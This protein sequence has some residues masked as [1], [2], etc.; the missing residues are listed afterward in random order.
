MIDAEEREKNNK[1]AA[2]PAPVPA[3]TPTPEPTGQS[4]PLKA[5]PKQ[6]IGF[7]AQEAPPQPEKD[8]VSDIDIIRDFFALCAANDLEQ[9]RAVWQSTD[10]DLAKV[11]VG[12]FTALQVAAERGHIEMMQWLISLGADI[13]INNNDGMSLTSFLVMK[14]QTDAVDL[15]IQSGAC[16]NTADKNGLTALHLAAAKGFYE[17]VCGMIEN[18]APLFAKDK[19]GHMAWEYAE[20]KRHKEVVQ[21]L[22]TA[23][24]AAPP[25][26]DALTKEMPDLLTAVRKG[27]AFM[28]QHYIDQGHDVNQIFVDVAGKKATT[29]LGLA[30]EGGNPRAVEILLDHGAD[31]NERLLEDNDFY[32]DTMKMLEEVHGIRLRQA[33]YPVDDVYYALL[34]AFDVIGINLFS[35]LRNPGPGAEYSTDYMIEAIDLMRTEVI[36]LLIHRSFDINNAPEKIGHRFDKTH[37]V[38]R[39]IS[40]YNFHGKIDELTQL[41]PLFLEKYEVLDAA[42]ILNLSKSRWQIPTDFINALFEKCHDINEQDNSGRTLLHN[43]IREKKDAFVDVLL[44]CDGLDVNILDYEDFSPM[45]YACKYAKPAT[46]RALLQMGAD[47]DAQNGKTNEPLALTACKARRLDVLEVLCEFGADINIADSSGQSLLHTACAELDV[48]WIRFLIAS[49][50]KTSASDS[51]GDTPLHLLVTGS[52]PKG[53]TENNISKAKRQSYILEMIDFLLEA[54]AELDS[55]NHDMRTPFFVHFISPECDTAV[56]KH[57]LSLGAIV[58]AQD[59][60]DWTCLHYA[61]DGSDPG[62][63]KFLLDAGADS[64]IQNNEGQSPYQIALDKNRRAIISMIE[65]AEVEINL[66]GD[67]MDAAFMRACKNGRRGVAEMLVKSGN[68]DITYVDDFGRTPLHYIAKMGMTALA[69]FVLSKGVDVNYTDNAGQTALHFA[70]GNMQKEVFKLL[71]E[72]G[73]DMNI[74]NDKGILPIHLVTNRGQHDLLSMML[75]KGANT[76]TATNAGQSLLHTACYTRSRECV[77][78]LLSL[79]V[80]PNATDFRGVSPL[81]VS[82]NINQKEI[83]K[84]LLE[85]GANIH[86]KNTE[87]EE[88]IHIAAIRGFKDMLALLLESGSNINAMC[89][90]GLSPLHYAAYYGYKDIFKF[91]LEKGADFELKT[92][93]GKSCIDIAAENGQKELIELIGVIQKRRGARA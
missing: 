33:F 18:G 21:L 84:I 10:I 83:V 3:S 39:L 81:V 65:K 91:L 85:A 67:D 2:K 54:G 30:V 71:V 72:H 77:R 55:L 59:K 75:E 46:V 6:L 34:K 44:G 45:Y 8:A 43:L 68:I 73:A 37:Y 53:K 69:K 70:A 64:N 24:D 17:L 48:E 62:K 27:N 92:G 93:A 76:E 4:L 40:V 29:L 90:R 74:P 26:V 47:I 13:N 22:R 15:L 7:L 38:D 52:L 50:A 14:S 9:A 89:G 87:G 32:E 25:D 79:G 57:L 28:I 82:V 78:V 16:L 41:F 19:R 5:K 58:D 88:G 42:D 60:R 86:S 11:Q 35:R 80:D 51:K 1:P 20:E 12:G 49:G 36:E 23:M 61:A 66:E 31:V 63:V 56:L